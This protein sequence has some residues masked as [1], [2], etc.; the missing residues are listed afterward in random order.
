MVWP[1]LIVSFVFGFV[2][3]MMVKRV[4][5]GCLALLVVPLAMIG[6]VYWVHAHQTRIDALDV[7]DW[8]F[9]PLTPSLAASAGFS[10][11][12]LREAIGRPPQ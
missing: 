2:T 6:Y 11:A 7:L 12:W 5:I 10:M 1:I 8:F 4:K 3:R 9:G